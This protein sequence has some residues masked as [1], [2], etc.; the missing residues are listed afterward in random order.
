MNLNNFETKLNTDNY[1][2]DDVR[3]LLNYSF[4]LKATIMHVENQYET[5][6]SEFEL[7]TLNERDDSIYSRVKEVLNS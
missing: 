7:E 2:K 4:R 6:F 1:T 3:R 5:D